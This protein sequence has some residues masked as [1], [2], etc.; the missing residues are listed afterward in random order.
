LLS[1]VSALGLRLF[2]KVL[3]KWALVCGKTL[4]PAAN[5]KEG[6]TV[7]EKDWSKIGSS[8]GHRPAGS[9]L[10]VFGS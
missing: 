2:Q 5:I 4:A 1:R 7:F 6:V 3:R 9:V 8:F 10:R